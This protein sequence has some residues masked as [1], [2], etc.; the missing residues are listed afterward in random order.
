MSLLVNEFRDVWRLKRATDG[1]SFKP[2]GRAGSRVTARLRN[3]SNYCIQRATAYVTL[4]HSIEDI[5]DP[6]MHF[7][8]FISPAHRRKLQGDRLCWSV[9]MP[10]LN[11]MSVDVFPGEAQLLDLADFGENAEW[12]EIPSEMGYSSSQTPEE[13]RQSPRPISS[14][15]F[16]RADKRY[17][18]E[19]RIVSRN[20]RARIFKIEIDAR[21][22]DQP[23]RPVG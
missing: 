3:G 15:I 5:L 12:I 14:R 20:T 10:E 8:A 16:L 22:R 2:E 19:V 13:A 4:H 9:T 18:A 1:L 11:P 21:E 6:P 23:V 17:Q 7:R